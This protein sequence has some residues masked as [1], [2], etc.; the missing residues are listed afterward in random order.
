[1]VGGRE[2]KVERLRSDLV[3]FDKHAAVLCVVQ[4][5]GNANGQE[6]WKERDLA[7]EGD[8]VER[9]AGNA[10][11]LAND[12]SKVDCKAEPQVGHVQYRLN[13]ENL[14]VASFGSVFFLD[15]VHLERFFVHGV[16]L[17]IK[18]GK[19]QPHQP[20]W[21]EEHADQKRQATSTRQ[22]N[23]TK[24]RRA[25]RQ[26]FRSRRR[27]RWYCAPRNGVWWC[28][29][30]CVHHRGCQRQRKRSKGNDNS[31]RRPGRQHIQL[32]QRSSN[33]LDPIDGA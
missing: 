16:L 9:D 11:I 3:V 6:R 30:V 26:V 33:A 17:P 27:C 25:V 10:A 20:V 28:L 4:N 5:H 24:N 29:V 15:R 2:R 1:M 32:K 18:S 19:K 13:N 31:P 8:R 14:G 12:K 21:R 22:T 7:A 23:A